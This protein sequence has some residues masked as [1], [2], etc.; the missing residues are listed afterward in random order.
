[1]V[2]EL[3]GAKCKYFDVVGTH[4]FLFKNFRWVEELLGFH[5]FGMICFFSMRDNCLLTYVTELEILK[6]TLHH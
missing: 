3:L 1:M 5:L 4:I 6:H 2:L